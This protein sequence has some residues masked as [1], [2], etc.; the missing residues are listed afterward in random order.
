MA[1]PA[2]A[3]RTKSLSYGHDLACSFGKTETGRTLDF[4]ADQVISTELTWVRS[5]SAL[6]A[7]TNPAQPNIRRADMLAGAKLAG[8][9]SGGILI[10]PGK[11]KLFPPINDEAAAAINSVLLATI[12]A[13][14]TPQDDDA[15]GK[16]LRKLLKRPSGTYLPGANLINE[17]G[18]LAGTLQ[19][20][21]LIV[22]QVRVRGEKRALAPF[23]FTDQAA[24][25][26]LKVTTLQELLEASRD[27]VD[28]IATRDQI[29]ADLLELGGDLPSLTGLIPGADTGAAVPFEDTRTGFRAAQDFV[30]EMRETLPDATCTITRTWKRPGGQG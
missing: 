1:N 4:T 11:A 20:P 18:T 19:L 28:T 3:R 30:N 17:D 26:L 7:D 5:D 24:E 16:T 29:V 25:E 15:L 22:V 9:T 12:A 8:I 2:F 13:S 27:T 10:R 14:G 6:T 23:D 21:R